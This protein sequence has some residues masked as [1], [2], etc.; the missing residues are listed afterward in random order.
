MSDAPEA[1][2]VYSWLFSNLDK[3]IN[4]SVQVKYRFMKAEWSDAY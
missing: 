1:A 4:I 2:S 3:K